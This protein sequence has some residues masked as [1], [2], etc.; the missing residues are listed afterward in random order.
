MFTTRDLGV[1]LGAFPPR[2]DLSTSLLEN[3]RW[4]IRFRA[5]M[6]VKHFQHVNRSSPR[7]SA[8]RWDMFL[9]ESVTS[10]LVSQSAALAVS[11]HSARK[12]MTYIPQLALQGKC[13]HSTMSYSKIYLDFCLITDASLTLSAAHKHTR[14]EKCWCHQC[15]TA[16]RRM[17]GDPV[18][19]WRLK[20]LCPST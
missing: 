12:I 18:M 1:I 2:V 4:R 11:S 15:E 19:F 14:L 10:W 5:V 20:H 9:P 6:E 13:S 8:H 17:W 3:S 16:D 7:L